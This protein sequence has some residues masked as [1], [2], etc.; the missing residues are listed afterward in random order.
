MRLLAT[1]ER[2]T[3]ERDEARDDAADWRA[4]AFSGPEKCP[5]TA[6]TDEELL[7][8]WEPKERLP[9]VV[10]FHKHGEWPKT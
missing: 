10:H 1:I 2:L 5:T 9:A 4:I 8:D 3:K 6:L 7:F